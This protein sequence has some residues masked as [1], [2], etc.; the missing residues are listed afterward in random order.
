MDI[1]LK[2]RNY[3]W[4][5]EEITLSAVLD[6]SNLRHFNFSVSGSNFFASVL[7]KEK[8]FVVS[9]SAK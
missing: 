2:N 9:V 4:K 3:K 6:K 7:F 8:Y 5:P 1:I